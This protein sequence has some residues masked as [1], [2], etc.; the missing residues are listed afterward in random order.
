[1]PREELV[2]RPG[3]ISDEI[4]SGLALELLVLEVRNAIRTMRPPRLFE[5][6]VPEAMAVVQL[7]DEGFS[8]AAAWWIVRT[9]SVEN[10][11]AEFA[12]IGTGSITQ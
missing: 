2:T 12:E 4:P 8:D 5:L 10:C 6:P 1:M 3:G 11:L 9:A 7:S